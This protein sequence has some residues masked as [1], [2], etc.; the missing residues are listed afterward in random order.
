MFYPVKCFTPAG[1]LKK[2]INTEALSKKHWKEIDIDTGSIQQLKKKNNMVELPPIRI[3]NRPLILV[4]AIWP[5][6][7]DFKP[8]GKHYIARSCGGK[9]CSDYCRSQESSRKRRV[10]TAEKNALKE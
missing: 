5:N 3:R 1:K 6:V 7:C 8:C 9:Y 4:C 2:I 10:K